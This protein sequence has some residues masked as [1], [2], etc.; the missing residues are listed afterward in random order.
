VG[1]LHI[2]SNKKVSSSTI[3]GW[4]VT[5]EWEIF[6]NWHDHSAY[7]EQGI[8]K[9]HFATKM[10]RDVIRPTAGAAFDTFKEQAQVVLL[11]REQKMQALMTSHVNADPPLISVKKRKAPPATA[12]TSEAIVEATFSV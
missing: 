1:A 9:V 11:A 8:A 3:Q 10:F 4:D 5:S 7:T 12:S 6:D 2:P